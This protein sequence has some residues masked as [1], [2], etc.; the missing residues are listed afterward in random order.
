MSGAELKQGGPHINQQ[1]WRKKK[2]KDEAPTSCP[3]LDPR[4]MVS[5]EKFAGE[6]IHTLLAKNPYQT[7][8]I[9]TF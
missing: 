8:P 9:F 7:L 4:V 1:N 6:G 3:G 5:W 2:C